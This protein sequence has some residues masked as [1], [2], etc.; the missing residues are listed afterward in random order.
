MP[1]AYGRTQPGSFFAS[2]SPFKQTTLILVHCTRH[3]DGGITPVPLR[4]YQRRR[5][6][7][8][9]APLWVWFWALV[10]YESVIIGGSYSPYFILFVIFRLSPIRLHLSH[11]EESWLGL[12]Y[13]VFFYFVL[14]Y[15][16]QCL[17]PHRL[18]GETLL[19]KSLFKRLSLMNKDIEY[20]DKKLCLCFW[21]SLFLIDS[22]GGEA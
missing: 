11:F 2:L 8:T 19:C 10:I 14:L 18:C 20:L 4:T 6:R 1:I 5:C 15:W 21:F 12:V 22:T 7:V 9:S 13:R 17:L 16:V 3:G